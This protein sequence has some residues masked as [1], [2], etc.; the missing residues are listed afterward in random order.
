MKVHTSHEPFRRMSAE[1][2]LWG[3]PRI[4][5]ELARL[6]HDIAESTVAKY[7]VAQKDRAP[8][9][10]WRNFITNHMGV[11]AA[12]DFFTVPTLTFKVLSDQNP[13]STRS[14]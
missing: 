7:M 9:Q 5:S 14:L 1:D 2:V 3:A 10:T 8:S 13:P 11:S 4:Q 12:R 6:G